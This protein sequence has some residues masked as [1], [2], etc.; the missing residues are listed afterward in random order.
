M[1]ELVLAGGDLDA[2]RTNLLGH[3]T[4]QCG[5]LLASQTE[6]PDGTVRLLVREIQ[7]PT[8]ADYSRQG[9]LE[10]ELRPEFVA[11]VSKV[12]RRGGYSLIFAH[13]HPGDAPPVFSDK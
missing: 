8:P 7:Y 12:A 2:L 4:E 3:G 6:R 13:S 11:R 1:I 5:V 10:A 9:P